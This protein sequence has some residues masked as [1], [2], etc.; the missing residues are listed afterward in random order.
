MFALTRNTMR[1]P[2]VLN[3]LDYVIFNIL[4]CNTDAHAKN[5]S[6]M[7]SGKGFSLAPLYDVMC[8][9]AWDGTTRNLAQ[10]VAGKNRGEHLKRRHWQTFAAECGLNAPRLIKRV[11]ELANAVLRE[12]KGSA[13]EVDVMPA[14]THVM[15]PPFV[16][17]IETRARAII[18]GL[19][20]T[21]DRPEPI[22]ET[23]QTRAPVAKKPRKK[24]AK[25]ATH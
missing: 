25:V 10:T 15:M 22:A 23:Q 11:E 18:S 1:A 7:I 19:N 3:L 13:A 24:K 5:Y 2:D 16:A 14:G 8:A 17:A 21:A 4:V 9:A 12:A 20:E 6:L